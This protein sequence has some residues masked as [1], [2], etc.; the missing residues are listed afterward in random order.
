MVIAIVCEVQRGSQTPGWDRG[1]K[2]ENQN[3]GK[4]LKGCQEPSGG[5]LRE[6]KEE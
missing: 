5:G 1:E 4:E 3:W 6:W 2:E